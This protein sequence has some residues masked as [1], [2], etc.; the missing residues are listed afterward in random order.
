MKQQNPIISFIKEAAKE[1][2]DE[3][4]GEW[5][6]FEK[7]ADKIEQTGNIP[8]QAIGIGSLTLVMSLLLIFTICAF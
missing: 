3:I 6:D 5:S 2:T 7:Q 8:A 4:K 1:V